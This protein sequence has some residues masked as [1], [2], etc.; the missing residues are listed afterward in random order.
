[1]Q[2]HNDQYLSNFQQPQSQ[3][4][5]VKKS[6]D[7]PRFGKGLTIGF[8]ILILIWSIEIMSEWVSIQQDKENYYDSKNYA[9]SEYTYKYKE[10][11]PDEL[12]I[13]DLEKCNDLIF[14]E[15]I[16]SRVFTVSI[17]IVKVIAWLMIWSS[18][19]RLVFFNNLAFIKNKL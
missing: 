14:E 15:N 8:A 11:D 2:P 6:P 12:R 19:S 17:E 18:L 7:G 16:D 1:M 5:I 3:P 13:F 10:C 9:D 4:T